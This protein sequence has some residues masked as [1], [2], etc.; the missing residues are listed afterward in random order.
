MTNTNMTNIF[1]PQGCT[2]NS[3][4]LSFLKAQ[5]HLL[6]DVILSAWNLKKFTNFFKFVVFVGK[7]WCFIIWPNTAYYTT[8]V[9]LINTQ[10]PFTRDRIR[11]I[12]TSSSVSLRSYLLFPLFL[13]YALIKFCNI[14]TN[15]RVILVLRL[16]KLIWWPYGS[17]PVWTGSQSSIYINLLK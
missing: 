16:F 15:L 6:S 2:Y 4:V 3:V 14:I 11:V 9:S 12:S 5:C 10:T 1:W 7:E 13:W 8:K 17:G